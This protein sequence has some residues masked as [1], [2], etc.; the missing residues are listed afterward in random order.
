MPYGDISKRVKQQL[1]ALIHSDAKEIIIHFPRVQTQRGSSD[2]GLF[3]IAFITTLCSGFDP[4]EIL[5]NQGL[6]RDHLCRCIE[7]REITPFP[8]TLK[9][10]QHSIQQQQVVLIYCLCRQ[11]EGGT[12]AECNKCLEWFHEE[13]VHFPKN[14]KQIQ[15]SCPR[16]ET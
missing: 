6:F 7:N 8:C 12:M 4:S 16:C 5:Y 14:I 1:C 2:C 13:C 15:W 3:S 10:R 9:K 11:P